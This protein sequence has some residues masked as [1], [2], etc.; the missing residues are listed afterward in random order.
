MGIFGKIIGIFRRKKKEPPLEEGP[1][2]GPITPLR[3]EAKP[4]PPPGEPLPR[5]PLAP[6]RG[7]PTLE[8]LSPPSQRMPEREDIDVSNIKAKIDLLLTQIES[9]KIQ[10]KNLEERLKSIEKMLAE[11][12]GIRYY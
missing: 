4:L 7:P 2:L 8:P 12:K 1:D 9:V 6:A 5:E 11:M 3:T 10:N